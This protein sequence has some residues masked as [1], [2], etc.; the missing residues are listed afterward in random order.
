MGP[1]IGLIIMI[2]HFCFMKGLHSSQVEIEKL[3]GTYEE[4][5][6]WRKKWGKCHKKN[7]VQEQEKKSV[8]PINYDYSIYENDSQVADELIEKKEDFSINAT[9]CV[10]KQNH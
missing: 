8:S 2:A 6:E 5:C 7:V 1:I 4:K 10:Q 9:H 3:N